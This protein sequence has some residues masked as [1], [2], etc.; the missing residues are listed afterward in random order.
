MSV[1]DLIEI[2]LFILWR[3]IT[4]DQN[5]FAKET[6]FDS[7][8]WIAAGNPLPL[9]ISI[10]FIHGTRHIEGVERMRMELGSGNGNG[11]WS[12]PLILLL[13]HTDT[14]GTFIHWSR[15]FILHVLRSTLLHLNIPEPF[16]S[17]VHRDA[18]IR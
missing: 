1:T 18:I 7:T 3:F 2:I 5:R 4:I 9:R 8:Q 10:L 12:S 14:S 6:W 16:D 13:S 17:S 15:P 11:I